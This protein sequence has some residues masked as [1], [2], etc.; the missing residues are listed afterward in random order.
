MRDFLVILKLLFFSVFPSDASADKSPDYP[1]SPKI[2][3]ILT[4]LKR[5]WPRIGFEVE[6]PNALH[7]GE[8]KSIAK[9]AYWNLET[10]SSEG[11]GMF[12]VEYISKP[13]VSD[14]QWSTVL[15]G[16][17][18]QDFKNRKKDLESRKNEES[19]N[20]DVIR[21]QITFQ[22][23]LEYVPLIMKHLYI[24]SGKK[25]LKRI[26]CDKKYEPI[27]HL[28]LSRIKGMLALFILY[29][30]QLFIYP[31]DRTSQPNLKPRVGGV[32]S[33]FSFSK[34]YNSLT[35][36]EKEFF[37][38]QV[39]KIFNDDFTAKKIIKYKD[40]RTPAGHHS[41]IISIKD[42][43]NSIKQPRGFSL[44]PDIQEIFNSQKAKDKKLIAQGG[45]HLSELVQFG[46][47]LSP[48]PDLG[49]DERKVGMGAGDYFPNL[50]ENLYGDAL[51]EIRLYGNLNSK[52]LMIDQ[53]QGLFEA[54]ELFINQIIALGKDQIMALLK[55]QNISN[56]EI[57]EKIYETE[58]SVIEKLD[59]TFN[60]KGDYQANAIK[61]LK[62]IQKIDKGDYTEYNS[63]TD[64]AKRSNFLAKWRKK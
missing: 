36:D 1:P 28:P 59:N 45:A 31:S 7:N 19:N 42:W 26:I 38:K 6:F 30:N 32:M 24:I 53:L 5:K 4:S 55:D 17:I 64:G 15:A 52:L 43:L 51:I 16:Q 20:M 3:P 54:E 57:Y 48:P 49:K 25:E 34:M 29:V 14:W 40:Y 22:V 33:R 56:E 18:M 61:N 9:S 63:A 60:S 47:I 11:N 41:L 58:R 23:G 50:E 12:D 62:M 13:Y 46:D 10:D 39:K 37:E 2:W 21:P 44:D 27:F 35:N 8:S